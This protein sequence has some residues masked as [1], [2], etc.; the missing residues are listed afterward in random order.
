MSI[1]V[2]SGLRA[3]EYNWM[4]S[5]LRLVPIRTVCLT[6]HRE[7]REVSHGAG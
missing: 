1:A 4:A 3:F 5:S 7:Q 2:V 6:T